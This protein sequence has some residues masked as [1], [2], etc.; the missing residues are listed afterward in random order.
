VLQAIEIRFPR[1]LFYSP[2]LIPWKEI[3]SEKLTV[4][5]LVKNFPASYGARR[6]IKA[7]T[8]ARPTLSQ[9]NPVLPLLRCILAYSSVSSI[10][11]LRFRISRP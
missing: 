10:W 7:F 5:Q 9:M 4:A 8:R 1:L 2:I 6:S 11:S 3:L